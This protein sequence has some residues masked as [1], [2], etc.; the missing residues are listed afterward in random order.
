VSFFVVA[1]KPHLRIFLNQEEDDLKN[2]RDFVAPQLAFVGDSKF[3][4]IYY[5]HHV[6]TISGVAAV[7]MDI[8]ITGKVKIIRLAYE[9]PPG[10]GFGAEAVEGLRNAV[11]IPG[12]RN[13]KAVPCRFTFPVIFSSGRRTIKTG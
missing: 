8:N 13:G 12:F 4:G 9:H 11:F 2:G 3:K 1:G 10:K 5:P 7:E 6:A